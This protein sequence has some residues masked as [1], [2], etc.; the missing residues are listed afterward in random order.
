MPAASDVLHFLCSLERLLLCKH[1][2]DHDFQALHYPV[3]HRLG[4]TTS[5]RA[6]TGVMLRQDSFKRDLDTYPQ[7]QNKQYC[8][9]TKM[10][11]TAISDAKPEGMPPMGKLESIPRARG[12]KRPAEVLQETVGEQEQARIAERI[13]LYLQTHPGA[14]EP[15]SA[16]FLEKPLTISLD[17][18]V[19]RLMRF[20]NKWAEETDGPSSIGV[21]CAIIAVFYLKRANMRLS[22]Q[23]IHRC[24][25]GSF[26]VAI[27][28]MYDFYM[29][30]N[31]WANVGGVKPHE[32]NTIEAA[33][34]D[35][36]SWNFSVSPA[37]FDFQSKFFQLGAPA[38]VIAG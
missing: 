13:A 29:S 6:P 18:F 15:D 14:K 21:C 33:F 25:L 17:K 32:V 23:T 34:C 27:K 3:Q 28:M 2:D 8:I 22:S 35:A 38:V 4:K 20:F 31:Y 7:Q 26:L 24:Y 9:E 12:Q 19:D 37:D 30:N 16:F 10:I 11:A 5:P 1:D 36:L